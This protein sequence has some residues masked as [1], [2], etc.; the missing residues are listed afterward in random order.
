MSSRTLP[1]PRHTTLL[2]LFAAGLVVRLIILVR[3]AHLAPGVVDEQHYIALASNV[4]AGNGFGWGPGDLTSIR[5]PLFPGLLVALW[6]LLGSQ[7]LQAVRIVQ[8]LLSAATAWLVYLLGRRAFNPTVGVYAAAISWLYPSLIFFDFLILTETLFTGLLVAFLLTAVMLVQQPRTGT[9]VLCGAVLALAA[10]TRSVLWPVPTLLCPLLTLLIRETWPRRLALSALVL[11]GYVAVIAPWAVRNTRLQ[12]VTTIVDTMGGI[13]LRMGNY[14]YTPDDR[15]W[16]AVSIRGDKNW[17]HGFTTD[18]PDQAPTEGRKD[19]WAQ[20][21]AIEYMRAHPA[22]TL[23]RSFIKFA[24]FW[25]LEREFIAG[26][27]QGLYAPPQWFA[28]AVA[29][30]IVGGYVLLSLVGAA[31]VWLAPPSDSR[32]HVLLLF[33]VVIIMGAHTI[34]FAHSRYHVPLMPILGVY[35]SAVAL[36]WA[37]A[38]G[39]AGRPARLAA[40]ASVAALAFIWVRQIVLVDLDRI[41]TMIGRIV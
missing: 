17:V 41:T 34:V 14:E 7:S 25:G 29:L 16:D 32:I 31:G 30:L 11:A 35:A 1:H 18:R 9:A 28:I 12:Q 33:P 15:M 13:N 19:K 6:G 38:F 23:R 4:L 21:K 37:P 8:I 24:D 27:Q 26:V 40:L 10:L 3:V 5:P 36:A 22:I 20:R 39:R 2:A